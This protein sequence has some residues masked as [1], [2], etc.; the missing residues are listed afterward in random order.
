MELPVEKNKEYIV[1]I[2]DNGYEGEGIAKIDGYT[3][4]IPQAIKRERVRI[5]IL[6]TT[7]SHA[8]GKLIDIIEPS[9]NR[10]EADCYTYKRCGGCN[11]RH[12]KYIE[13]LNIKREKVQNLVNKTLMQKIEVKNTIEMKEP[14]YYRNKAQYPIGVDNNQIPILG[15][16]AN[17]THNIIQIDECLIQNPISLKIAKFILEYIKNN[18]I[19]VYN[20]NNQ[21]GL[22][23]HIIIKIGIKTNEVMCILVINGN[24]FK[25]EME[26]SDQLVKEFPNIKTIIKN[27]NKK[28]TNVILGNKNYNLFGN[29][30]IYDKLENYTFK[31]SPMSFY[32][33]NPIQTEILYKIAIEKAKLTG[34]E[35]VFDLYC[36]IGT[37]G[38]FVSKY[39]KKV[40]G[41][42]IVEQAIED[43][44]ENAK[45]NKISNIEFMTGDVGKVLESLIIAKKQFPDVMFLDPPR[46]GLDNETIR[47]ILKYKPKKVIY[48]SCNPATLIRDL[49]SLEDKYNIKEIQPVD[50]FPFTSHV[51]C[52]A[53]MTL[54]GNL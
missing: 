40:Y 21:K 19:S 8:Y 31:I 33:V 24:S 15:I 6:K 32:Q 54:K 27:I 51:E 46:R 50:M 23:R 28:N 20:E 45:I 29:G 47:N 2:I 44:K 10:V 14:Y 18:R 13:T 26:L 38:I 34:E 1:D 7:V 11:L 36:G 12:I 16:Y 22:I 4:F 48:I 3:I 17:R 42:E 39:A 30:Y 49:K 53:V 37:I 41:I 35:V 9:Q 43:A 25:Q 52:C 5:L